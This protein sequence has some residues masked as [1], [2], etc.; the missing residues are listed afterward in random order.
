MT[1]ARQEP[2]RYRALLA[3]LVCLGSLPAA[4][5]PQ[6][7]AG[8][9]EQIVVDWHTGLAIGGYDPVA[10]FTDGKPTQGRPE[11]EL[12]YRGAVWR[13]CN[14]GNRAAF[15][16]HP[17]IYMP[18]FGGYDPVSVA[19]G[20]AVA[21]NP[22]FWVIADQR[23]FLFYDRG[24]RETFAADPRRFVGAARRKWPALLRILSP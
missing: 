2:K 16:E 6:A 24:R 15:A 5:V 21:G 18:Q 4:I 9:T 11:F 14:V 13:F 20:V 3:A 7:H 1:A 23:L 8:L 12:R 10:F 22:D 17:D 19:R